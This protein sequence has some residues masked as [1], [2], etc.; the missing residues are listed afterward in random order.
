MNL[1]RFSQAVM[2]LGG[3]SF[4]AVVFLV[5]VV[6]VRIARFDIPSSQAFDF[7]TVLL[8]SASLALFLVS[9][10]VA[11]IAIGGAYQVRSWVNRSVEEEAEEIRET[12]SAKTDHVLGLAFGRLA[13]KEDP[14][15]VDREELLEKAIEYE[16]NALSKYPEDESLEEERTWVRN[17]LAFYYALDGR[18]EHADTALEWAR[19]LRR[20]HGEYNEPD[21]MNTYLRVVG[22][23]YDE[24][25]RPELEVSR[26]LEAG[27][28]FAA[29]LSDDDHQKNAR[30]HLELVS[31]AHDLLTKPEE[32]GGEAVS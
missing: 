6:G 16:R 29:G 27:K 25:D 12:L 23:F 14:H 9:M 28:S 13:R 1:K 3:I 7:A 19:E 10:L 24:C 26:A 5:V 8:A 18:R 32:D 4:I 15:V 20:L 31:R 22:E 11:G 30:L 17:N 21:W 2:V